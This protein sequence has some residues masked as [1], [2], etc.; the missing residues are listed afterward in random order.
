MVWRRLSATPDAP[1][2]I[3]L[4]GPNRDM[5]KPSHQRRFGPHGFMTLTFD[6]PALV[7]RVHLSDGTEL[8]RKR[9]V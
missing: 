5:V 8:L 7:E 9:I 4:D 3:V 2:S 6:G 1:G